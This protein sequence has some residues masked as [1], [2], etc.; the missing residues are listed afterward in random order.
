MLLIIVSN[1]MTSRQ[2]NVDFKLNTKHCIGN[3]KHFCKNNFVVQIYTYTKY[4]LKYNIPFP[5]YLAFLKHGF[6]IC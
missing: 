1:V 5:F 2:P 6:L 3:R 4:D